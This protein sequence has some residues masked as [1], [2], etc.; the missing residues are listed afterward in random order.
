MM[1]GRAIDLGCGAGGDAIWLASQGWTVT[2]VDISQVAIDRA[3]QTAGELGVAVVW[4]GADYV[5][6]SHPEGSFDLVAALYPALLKSV[7]NVI[8]RAKRRANPRTRRP[9]PLDSSAGT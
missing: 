6:H 8:L 5:D 1:W 9:T 2:A 3:V 7:G 4:M